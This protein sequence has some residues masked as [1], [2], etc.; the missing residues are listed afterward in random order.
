MLLYLVLGLH[1]IF[2]IVTASVQFY[3]YIEHYM[4]EQI[5]RH[6]A[7]NLDFT[8]STYLAETQ[9]GKGIIQFR[10]LTRLSTDEQSNPHKRQV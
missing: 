8:P 5:F 4:T 7:H 10:G 2:L 3:S 1:G 9:E 6:E